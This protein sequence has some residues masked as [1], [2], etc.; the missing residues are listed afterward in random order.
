M[1]RVQPSSVV[2]E[3][4]GILGVERIGDDRNGLTA[5]DSSHAL[6]TDPLARIVR[7][8]RRS[9]SARQRLGVGWKQ[10]GE[11]EAQGLKNSCTLGGH[12]IGRVPRGFAHQMAPAGGSFLDPDPP[13]NTHLP[14]TQDIRRAVREDLL[15][16][17][18]IRW[19]AKGFFRRRAL[20]SPPCHAAHPQS[21]PP[22]CFGG[23]LTVP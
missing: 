20:R 16:H 13:E 12:R 19:Q 14:M 17:R 5:L 23:H 10:C 11:L 3:P 2:I 21:P 15:V 18:D 9:N 6:A 1:V 8:R 22:T 7:R 4:T